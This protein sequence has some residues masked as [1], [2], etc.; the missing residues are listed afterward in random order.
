MKFHTFGDPG[1]PAIMLIHGAGWS[2]WLY[3]RQA[4]KLQDRYRVILPVLDGHGEEAA[5]PY[6]STEAS[7]D[8]IIE[9]ID[10]NCGGRLYALSGVSLGGQIAIELLSRR[11]DIA[12]KAIIESGV[13]L[14]QP[15]L[16][17]YSLFALKLSGRLMFS[18]SFNRWALKMMPERMRLPQELQEL[19]LRDLPAVRPESLEAV[20]RTYFRYELK[21]SLKESQADTA[22]WYGGK[23]V[24]AVRQSAERLREFLPATSI[25]CLPG[26]IHA[27]IS[28][29][30]PNEWI[31]RAESFFSGDRGEFR[32]MLALSAVR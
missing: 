27:E 11:K 28:T 32:A 2:W 8:A 12:R 3:K 5:I 1:L 15:F 17:S 30:H 19:Y 25:L 9:Y 23:E 7:A 31:E 26:Y 6:V 22:Y 16:M 29:Y 20:F 24:R 14:P 4:E 18:E 13:C 10:H 21:E